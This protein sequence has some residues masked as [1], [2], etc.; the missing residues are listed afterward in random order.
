MWNS[1]AGLDGQQYSTQFMT[2]SGGGYVALLG[3][4]YVS[5]R[6]VIDRLFSGL[7]IDRG[8]RV[9]FVDFTVY[10]PNINLFGVCKCGCSS[11][12]NF[13]NQ[14]LYA[15]LY[16]RPYTHSMHRMV[17]EFPP[18]GGVITSTNIRPV[19]LIR[20]ASPFDYFVMACECIFCLFIF[21][22]IIEE[23]LEV[24]MSCVYAL[25][26]IVAMEIIVVA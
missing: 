18:T 10:N 14:S 11:F 3:K 23:L 13:I 1:E 20:Y 19:K 6:A 7:W 8:T 25:S 17:L 9:I 16:V 2:Y 4:S 22:Y 12:N 15:Y 21:Y 5:A 26:A 24:R